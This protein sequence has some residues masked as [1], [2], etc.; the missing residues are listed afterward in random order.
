MKHETYYCCRAIV[1]LL[2]QGRVPELV[3]RLDEKLSLLLLS[4]G[5]PALGIRQEHRRLLC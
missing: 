2:E 5:S 4:R 1:E 3:L